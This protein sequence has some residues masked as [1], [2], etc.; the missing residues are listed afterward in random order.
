MCTRF[1]ITFLLLDYHS[2]L[3]SLLG[4]HK[5]IKIIS[6]VSDRLHKNNRRLAAT[7]H[8]TKRINKKKSIRPDQGIRYRV[9]NYRNHRDV[10]IIVII[11]FF[12]FFYFFIF[13]FYYLTGERSIYLVVVYTR[14]IHLNSL[15]RVNGGRDCICQQI[16]DD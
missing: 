3:N 2:L 14:A 13:F 7:K 1:R 15:A 5:I 4:F 10:Q 12:Y 9:S 8:K 11:Y 6:R 16:G